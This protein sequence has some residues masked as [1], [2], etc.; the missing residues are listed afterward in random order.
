MRSDLLIIAGA[1]LLLS[2]SCTETIEQKNLLPLAEPEYATKVVKMSEKYEPKSFLVKFES[3]PTQEQLQSLVSEGVS[4]INPVFVSVKGKE[5]L[6]AQFGL[7]RWYSIDVNDPEKL[8][9]VMLSVASQGFV[10]TVEYN[11]LSEA[12]TQKAIPAYQEVATKAEDSP[13]NDPLLI[14][15][16]HYRNMGSA[17][18][19]R[20]AVKGA[21][22]NVYDV[23]K[24]LCTGDPSIIVAVI[25]EGIKYTHPD[26]AANMWKN[27]G[28]IP[29]NGI[30]DDGNGYVDDIYGYNFVRNSGQIVWTDDAASGHGTHCAGTI[31]AV[32]NNGKGVSG[33]AGGTGNNDGCRLMS[34]QIFCDSKYSTMANE[35]AAVKYAAD[36]GASVISCSFGTPTKIP[37]DNAYGE[38]IMVDALHYFEATKNN[39]AIDGSIAIFAA[40][41]E[42]DNFCHYPGALYDII[43]VSA[44]GPDFLPTYYTNYGNGCN[45]AAPGGEAYHVSG[46]FKS[47]VLSTVPSELEPL[48][49]DGHGKSDYGYMQGT[50][51]ACPHV[52]GV[53]ALALSY[54]Q[55]QG[56]H[57]TNDEFKRMILSSVNDIDQRIS[58]TTEKTYAYY[59]SPLKMAPYF[60]QMGTGAIDAWRLMMKIDGIPTSTASAGEKQ[61]VDLSPY[62]G[63]ASVSLT[64]LDVEVPQA[65][66][67]A[68][69]LQKVEATSGDAAIVSKD[70]YAVVEYGRLYIHPT[71]VGSG[72]LTIK[73]VGGGDHLGGGDNPT[74]GFEISSEVS[75]VTRSF[76]STNGGWL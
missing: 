58:K 35:V 59:Q 63:S 10:S 8:D 5:A 15:Q 40:G 1:S 69:G 36:N 71:K 12:P 6:E 16:W 39:N 22:V 11:S 17:A 64:Y 45:I 14:D 60:H 28:E 26:L 4:S 57:F 42:N 62:F 41:N 30:D 3:V 50:S 75:I 54:A 53:V 61:W 47:M 25:D 74:G 73:A 76:K 67:D 29:D 27:E 21:D 68:L 44:F 23:W 43:A 72:K 66:I 19:S 31:A 70:G 20:N 55:K 65:T 33:I 52:S 7:D 18:Y 46:S 24:N 48:L 38:E 56:K 32:N 2:V 51:M 9:D 49:A 37:S 34:C 13:F